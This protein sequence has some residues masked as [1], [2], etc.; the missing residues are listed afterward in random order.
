MG[1]EKI[2]D[3]GQWRA[4][5]RHKEIQACQIPYSISSSSIEV[6]FAN[7]GYVIIT[8]WQLKPASTGN[9]ETFPLH[10]EIIF[11]NL[12]FISWYF[13]K[14]VIVVLDDDEQEKNGEG[15]DTGDGGGDGDDNYVEDYEDDNDDD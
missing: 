15:D 2:T 7:I 10:T 4:F 12:E 5:E 9:Y 13:I 8:R 11:R 14:F 6:I 1:Y 3:N